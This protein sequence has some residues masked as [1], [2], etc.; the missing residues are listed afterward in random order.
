MNW[1]FRDLPT[2][3]KRNTLYLR[4]QVQF[5]LNLQISILIKKQIEERERERKK[6]GSEESAKSG[7]H[8]AVEQQL[9]QFKQQ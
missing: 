5:T 8:T 2:P 3:N 9:R 6:N 1:F 4:S 7:V